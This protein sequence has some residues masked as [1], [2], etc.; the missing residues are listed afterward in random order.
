MQ[1]VLIAL[2]AELAHLHAIGIVAPILFGDVVP[3]FALFA[4]H[5]DLG[6]YVACLGHDSSSRVLLVTAAPEW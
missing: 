6:T 5:R 1:G 3:V 2:R 4:R